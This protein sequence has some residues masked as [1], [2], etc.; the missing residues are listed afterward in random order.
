MPFLFGISK[1]TFVEAP[2]ACFEADC[3]LCFGF[4][5]GLCSASLYEFMHYARG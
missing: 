3:G 1:K 5:K 4:I 2:E